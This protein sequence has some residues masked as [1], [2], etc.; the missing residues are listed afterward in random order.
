[1][2][3]KLLDQLIGIG[4]V[5]LVQ[6]TEFAS[7]NVELETPGRIFIFLL[8]E[9]LLLF[10]LLDLLMQEFATLDSCLAA[11]DELADLLELLRELLRGNGLGN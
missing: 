9:L 11:G 6:F 8:E 1:M 4:F 5:H 10:K 2:K 3:L 7:D